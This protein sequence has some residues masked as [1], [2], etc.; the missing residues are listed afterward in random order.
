[1]EKFN[2]GIVRIAVFGEQEA[3][4]IRVSELVCP[5]TEKLSEGEASERKA[6]AKI[7]VL[8]EAK[9]LIEEE[10]TLS[11]LDDLKTSQPWRESVEF[12]NSWDLTDS[13]NRV[14]YEYRN[15]YK[16]DLYWDGFWVSINIF[17]I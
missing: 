14:T 2:N 15:N 3:N 8:A 16:C 6:R 13:I 11:K 5:T 10:H 1:M 17:R 4:Q 9:M 12:K 7:R